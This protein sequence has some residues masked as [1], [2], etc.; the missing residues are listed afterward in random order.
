MGK[1]EGFR[2]IG[3]SGK[4]RITCNKNYTLLRF[5][6]SSNLRKMHFSAESA[7]SNNH[8]FGSRENKRLYDAM[9]GD[10]ENK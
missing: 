4:M 5:K 6:R 7:E 1:A 8:I 2:G 3:F 10:G 9:F